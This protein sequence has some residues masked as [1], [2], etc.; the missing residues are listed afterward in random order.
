EFRLLQHL[1]EN[2]D[3]WERPVANSSE[4]LDVKARLIL[5]QITDVDEKNQ[6]MT[7][8][9]YIDYHWT[10][11]KL[12]WDPAQFG[13]IRDIRFSR[14]ADASHK[15]WK[16]DIL[17]FN[18]V[19][20]QV[21]TPLSSQYIVNHE[22]LV[23]QNPPGIFR[24]ACSI[25]I[26][27]FPFDDH[28]CFLKFGSWTYDGTKINLTM[29]LTEIYGVDNMF[30]SPIPERS[31]LNPESYYV[32]KSIDLQVYVAN[33]EWDLLG[34]PGRR[35]V[36]SFGDNVYHE[37]YCHIRT[38]RRTLAYGMNLIIPSHLISIMTVLGFTL[39]PDACEKTHLEAAILLSVIFFLQIVSDMSP[40]QSKAVPIL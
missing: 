14:A 15:I 24:F 17:M 6:V 21:S 12:R 22:G 32:N 29:Y 1:K 38:R 18:I 4:S 3:S 30:V 39:P 25:D 33:G 36:T 37:L 35:L 40:P 8:L 31:P 10:D 28:T 9:A 7:I 20:R 16:P 26:P 2:Y 34:T 19:S 11:Y 5:N 27:F 13:G 23:R